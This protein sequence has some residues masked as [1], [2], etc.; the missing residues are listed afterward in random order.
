MEAE[1][2]ADCGHDSPVKARFATRAVLRVVRTAAATVL[3]AVGRLPVAIRCPLS[4]SVE[5]QEWQRVSPDD[6]IFAPPTSQNVFD[7]NW[8]DGFFVIIFTFTI[9]LWQWSGTK[10]EYH[11]LWCHLSPCW[12]F[13]VE[14]VLQE[15]V[16][17]GT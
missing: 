8:R 16:Q 4:R 2:L 3:A 6:F 12:S 17:A 5:Q 13:F 7:H 14:L 10:F 9:C 1:L 15:V 11:S